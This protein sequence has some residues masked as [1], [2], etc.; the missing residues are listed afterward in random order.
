MT[1]DH[2][3]DFKRAS[4]RAYKYSDEAFQMLFE[5]FQEESELYCEDFEVTYGMFNFI[6]E[7][8]N[9]IQALPED[10]YSII[11]D[12]LWCENAERDGID[13]I[14]DIDYEPDDEQIEPHALN[15]LREHYETVLV[16]DY[17]NMI[18][19]FHDSEKR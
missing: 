17:S 1:I 18:I 5:H 13:D 7:Y 2:W 10:V 8:D 15:W 12:S 16:S 6:E 3:E 4:G 9:A 19:V 11:K 14:L